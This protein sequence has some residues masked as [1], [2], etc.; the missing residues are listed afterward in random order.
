MQIYFAGAESQAHLDTLRSCGVERVAVSVANLARHTRDYSNWAS[1]GRLAG[2]DWLI[3]ADSPNTPVA[4]LL[5]LL[6]GS[7][8]EPEAVVGPLDW[9]TETWLNDSDIMFLPIWDGHDASNLRHFVEL[10][11]GTVLPDAVVDNQLAV[12]QARAAM[13]RMSTLGGLTGRSKG[14]DKFDLLVSSAWWAAQKHG[15]TQVWV[16]NR[17]VR[18]NSDD[19]H[20]KRQRYVEQIEAL[21]AD[22]SAVLMDDP[23]ETAK[24]AVL[25]WL[26]MESFLSTGHALE[27]VPAPAI[28]GGT[29]TITGGPLV[30][31]HPSTGSVISGNQNIAVASPVSPLRHKKPTLLPIMEADTITVHDDAGNEV[32]QH[33]TIASVAGSVRQCSTCALGPACPSYQPGN[34]CAY[35]IPVVIRTK[36]QRQA[37]LRV[38]AETQ[39]QRVLFA[40]FAEQVNGQGDATVGI[41]MDRLFRMVESWKRIEEQ[42]TKIN[43]GV[44]ATG[45]DADGSLGMI[46]RLFGSEAGQNARTLDVPILSD[47]LIEDADMV[48]GD[49][50]DDS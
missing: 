14:I 38:L 47:T 18:L 9:A 32:E 23:K 44:S 30:T 42:T 5:E 29:V 6:A 45:P 20:L 25:S 22:V 10:Y 4:P 33:N 8:G 43:I 41:E 1:Q 46:S 12:R 24:L 28:G 36:D 35:N 27:H 2:L 50:R 37:V 3:Y 40:A 26:A 21:G 7:S 15:E 34:S 49:T 17:M 11:D 16:G 31:S 39:T 48:D 19:K 13:G